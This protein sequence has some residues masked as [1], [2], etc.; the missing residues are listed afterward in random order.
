MIRYDDVVT[1]QRPVEEVFDFVATHCYENHPRWE[2]EVLEI[3]RITTGPVDVGSRA[4]MVRRDYGK[5]TETEY[6]VTEMEPNRRIAF[7]HAN[8]Q[9]GF[10]ISFD[11]EPDRA[12]THLRVA[13]RAQP[14]GILRM[15]TPLMRVRMPK[16]GRRLTGNIRRVVEESAEPRVA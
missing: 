11:F 14:H 10:D 13:V 2:P 12:G 15:M 16:T 8:A 1:I 7:R 5:V 6:E 3:R 9:M 4:V